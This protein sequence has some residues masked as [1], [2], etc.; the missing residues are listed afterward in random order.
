VDSEEK[1]RGK[2]KGG[3]R[4]PDGKRH[5]DRRCDF[6]NSLIECFNLGG[7]GGI[8]ARKHS[9]WQRGHQGMGQ[10]IFFEKKK[11]GKTVL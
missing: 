4:K 2:V 9:K 8:S 5:Q 7:E 1:E 11:T 10:S 6:G 3:E